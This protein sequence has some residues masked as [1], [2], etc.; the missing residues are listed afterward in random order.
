V[1]QS[2]KQTWD[3]LE[4]AINNLL[5]TRDERKGT[6]RFQLIREDEENYAV[7][8]ISTHNPNT[9]RP[10]E[11]RHTRHAFVVPVATFNE[12]TWVRW[13]FE[14]IASIE[15][16]ETCESFLYKGERIYAPH[17][18]N[19]WYPYHPWFASYPEEKLKAPGEE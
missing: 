18:G 6:P 8:Y 3:F 17:H 15:F 5:Y 11:I 2:R 12:L 7:L 4:Q 9:Y 13:V 19:G 1:T 16:H 14:C 10:E